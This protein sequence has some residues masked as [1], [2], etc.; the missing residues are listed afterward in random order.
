MRVEALNDALSCS[1]V[2]L[3][4]LTAMLSGMEYSA[5]GCCEKCGNTSM[6]EGRNHFE[7]ENKKSRAMVELLIVTGR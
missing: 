1:I 3:L 7:Q 2:L 4:V 5:I 6:G